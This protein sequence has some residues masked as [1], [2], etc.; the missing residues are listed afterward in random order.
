MIRVLIVDDE[1]PA[2]DGLRVRLARHADFEIAGEAASGRAAIEEIERVRPDLMFLDV[3]MP[4]MNGFEVLQAVPSEQWPRVIFVTA[5]DQHALR[6]FDMHALDY[7]LKPIAQE[8]FDR[9]LERARAAHASRLASGTL[10]SLARSLREAGAGKYEA[11]TPSPDV[12]QEHVTALQKSATIDRLTVRDGERLR[13]VAVDTIRWAQACG[14]Y[15]TL[16]VGDAELL[17][18]I[19]LAELERRLPARRFARIHRTAIVNVAEVA[20]ILPISHGDYDVVMRDGTRLRL[21]RRY[22]D[23]LL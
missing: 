9:A 23:R 16:R 13:V 21:S 4:D 15:V 20:E 18:R 7:L 8:R 1:R 17:H 3:R 2:R 10:E 19:A 6:A 22:R 14:N 5:Y 11:K 12:A